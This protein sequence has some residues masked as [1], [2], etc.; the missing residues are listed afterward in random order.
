MNAQ[1]MITRWGYR[2]YLP[3]LPSKYR[4][5]YIPYT[6]GVACVVEVQIFNEQPWLYMEELHSGDFATLLQ[7]ILDCWQETEWTS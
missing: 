2:R 6:D 3:L 1:K 7:E 5:Q 4:I